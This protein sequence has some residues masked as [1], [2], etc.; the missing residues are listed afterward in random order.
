LRIGYPS[1]LREFGYV[2]LPELVELVLI[3]YLGGG[4]AKRAAAS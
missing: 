3:P 1:H 2:K 4:E